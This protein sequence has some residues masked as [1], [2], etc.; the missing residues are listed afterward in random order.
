MGSDNLTELIKGKWFDD[1]QNGLNSRFSASG[2]SY[3]YHYEEKNSINSVVVLLGKEEIKTKI[4]LRDNGNLDFH[5]SDEKKGN[6]EEFENCS[7]EDFHTMLARAFIYIRDG[8]FDYHKE[9]HSN[10]KRRN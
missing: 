8:N 9:W 5:Y 3:N 1:Y 4:E 2:M 6:V 7:S 10:L